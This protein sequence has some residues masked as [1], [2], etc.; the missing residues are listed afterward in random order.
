MQ[1]MIY[2]FLYYLAYAQIVEILLSILI[3]VDLLV[4]LKT[5]PHEKRQQYITLFSAIITIRVLTY[6]MPLFLPGTFWPFRGIIGTGIVTLFMV[7]YAFKWRP[8][9]V[10]E[11]LTGASPTLAHTI[12]GKGEVV[13]PE[14][15]HAV[16]TQVAAPQA[17]TVHRATSVF[18][19]ILTVILAIMG[20]FGLAAA[21]FLVVL[22]Y[23]CSRPGA[24]CM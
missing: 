19:T 2:L 21:I 4:I 5:V 3:L 14:F 10:S 23:Q 22:T 8:R 15:H 7:L 20:L 24:K 11:Y 13:N 16:S 9:L 12:S 18:G 17:R 6:L 1:V